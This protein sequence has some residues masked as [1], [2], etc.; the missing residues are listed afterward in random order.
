MLSK[1]LRSIYAFHSIVNPAR[2]PDL[3]ITIAIGPS[4]FES[5]N[6]WPGVKFSHDFNLALGANSSG[7]W[8]TLL[9]SVPLACKTP[10]GKLCL[11]EYGNEPDL[12]STLAQG[13][14]LFEGHCPELT[15]DAAYGYLDPSFGGVGNG[16]ESPAAWSRPTPSTA[17]AGRAS[18]TP[19]VPAPWAVD[20]NLYAAG[21]GIKLMHMHMGTNYRYA[22]W[23]HIPIEASP[24]GTKTP[25]YG[26]ILVAPVLAH[27]PATLVSLPLP[28]RNNND[29]DDN[30]HHLQ[31][32]YAIYTRNSTALVKTRH[33]Q[34][35]KRTTPPLNCAGLV[36]LGP[37]QAT[38]PPPEREYT[39]PDSP[40]N[41]SSSSGGGNGSRGG[42]RQKTDGQR[43][44]RHHGHGVGRGGVATMSWVAGGR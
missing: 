26:N 39:F 7:E 42:E 21:T 34:P 43:E 1:T 38:I 20:F 5:Y 23:Q 10:R 35:S 18:P 12:Y 4:Y 13:P 28:S 15:T 2:L 33:P 44:R 9:G 27:Y 8:Q 24:M 22:S 37:S 36:P 32:A 41:S 29:D 19:L 31:Q 17:K 16:L 3:L 6:T 25:Y 30:D 14:M 40:L 11:W